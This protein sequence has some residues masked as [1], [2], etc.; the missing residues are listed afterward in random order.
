MQPF[1]V[2]KPNTYI[3]SVSLMSISTR[4]NRIDGI[5][6][7]VVAMG[8]EM[9][10]A[11]IRDLDL[12]APELDAAGPGD[13]MIVLE[14]VDGADRDAALAGVEA[15]LVRDEARPAGGGVAVEPPRT[16]G[17]AI[18]RAPDANLAVISVNGAFA[19]VSYTHL[20]LPTICS[21]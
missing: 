11:V 14:L 2:V 4:A 12:Y 20:T 5:A 17:A 8:T 16:L 10:L 7:A 18:G 1:A 3:D 21:V 19:A 13:L 15:L 6:Q 9:N